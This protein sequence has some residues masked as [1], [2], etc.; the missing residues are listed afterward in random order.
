MIRYPLTKAQELIWVGQQLN[1]GTPLYNTIFRYDVLGLI[2]EQCFRKALD[3]LI[4]SSDTLRTTFHKIDDEPVQVV[5]EA[6]AFKYE[7][8]IVDFS[9]DDHWEQLVDVWISNEKQKNLNLE[10]RCF[11]IAL[12]RTPKNYI[13]YINQHHL[14]TDGATAQYLYERL[15]YWYVFYKPESIVD[16]PKAFNLFNNY[17]E[18][19]NTSRSVTALQKEKEYWESKLNQLDAPANLYYANKSKFNTKAKRLIVGLSKERTEKIVGLADRDGIRSLM[20]PI[21]L[22]NIFTTVGFAFA[23]LLT[24]KEQV[25]IG[26]AFHNRTS[27]ESKNSLGLFTELFPLSVFFEEEDTFLSLFNK[28]REESFSFLKNAKPGLSSTELSKSFNVLVNY[29]P[30][31]HKNFDE[32]ETKTHWLLPDHSDT[33][34][35]LKIQLADYDNSGELKAHFDFIED[36]FSDVDIEKIPEQFFNLIDQFIENP[37]KKIKDCDL[38]TVDQKEEVIS[39]FSGAQVD[40]GVEETLI[41]LFDQKAKEISNN[42]ALKF[43]N[44]HLSFRD[45]SER[46]NRLANYLISIGVSS[47]DIVGLLLERSYDMV[48]GILAIQK[49]GAAYLPIEPIYPEGRIKYVLEDSGTNVVLTHRKHQN[50]LDVFQ[51]VTVNLDS[52]GEEFEKCRTSIVNKAKLDLP[53]YV[54][55]TSGSTGKPKGV[56][57]SHKAIRNRIL[58]KQDTFPI[59]TTDKVLQKTPFSFDVSVWEFMWPMITGAQLVIAK[60]EGHKDNLYL[61]N[62][63]KK[64]EISIVHFVPSMLTLFAANTDLKDCISLKHVF[65]SGEALSLQVAQQ[66]LKSVK[67]AQLHNLYGPTEAAVDVTY[68]TCTLTDKVIPIGKPV[69]NTAVY[70]LNASLEPQSPGVLGDLYI[71]GI[72]LAEGYLNNDILTKEKFIPNPFDSSGVS[73]IYKSGD[74]AS[75]DKDGVITYHGRSDHQVK[76]RGFRIELGEIES[77]LLSSGTIK[78]VKV[79]LIG[80]ESENQRLIAF[81]VR[82]NDFEEAKA[83]FF[84]NQYLPTYMVPSEFSYVDEI[85]LSTNGKADVKELIRQ[86]NEVGSILNQNEYVPPTTELEE[87][88]S[89]IWTSVFD[90]DEISIHANFL[91]LGGHSLLGI[92]IASRIKEQLEINIPLKAVL[93]A[94]SIAQL[95]TYL[96]NILESLLNEEENTN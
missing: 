51:G 71:G 69:S 17:V 90:L 56:V 11:E 60:P 19:E 48:I 84:L 62:L 42:I 8:P 13:I 94:P 66:F 91:E 81:I 95:S 49:A 18:I 28:A 40:Y 68:W 22:L 57:V 16:E 5:N 83:K 67:H 38:L 85:P 44:T 15:S 70:V 43:K 86:R 36:A 4:L 30:M 12:I 53:A 79:T 72:Q 65:S 77:V 41:G 92:K 27:L 61:E 64:E 87:F 55:Y 20:K 76:L 54:I 6:Y 58:W 32:I 37:D 96:E 39:H 73:R 52:A 50:Q 3:A 80:E 1:P 26:S 59:T 33:H 74:L 45:L 46:S 34:H 9:R 7:L 35:H 82:G 75:M 47:G 23:Y 31:T 89:D 63:I 78:N 14:I 10:E 88:V 2:D 21:T 29:I 24:K 93:E 25:V